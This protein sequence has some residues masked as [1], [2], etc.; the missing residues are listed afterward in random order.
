MRGRLLFTGKI[1][2]EGMVGCD[3]SEFQEAKCHGGDPITSKEFSS[4]N[5][6][7]SVVKNPFL[8]LAFVHLG[9]LSHLLQ[10]FVFFFSELIHP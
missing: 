4:H 8:S 9:K 1:F 6:V 3:T 7:A 2:C 5:Q 10:M